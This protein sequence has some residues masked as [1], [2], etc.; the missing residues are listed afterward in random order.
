M[1]ALEASTITTVAGKAYLVSG[2]TATDS[3]NTRHRKSV[4]IIDWHSYTTD[5]RMEAPETPLV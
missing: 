5:D 2:P 4:H 3:A 1:P